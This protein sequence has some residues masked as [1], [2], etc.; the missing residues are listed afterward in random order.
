MGEKDALYEAM[1]S[2]V[3]S[4]NLVG[5]VGIDRSIAARKAM[6]IEQKLA[7]K[8]TLG[9]KYI[10]LISSHTTARYQKLHAFISTP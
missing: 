10:Q 6:N 9:L 3:P 2:L 8:E 1:E 7:E 5:G 4:F